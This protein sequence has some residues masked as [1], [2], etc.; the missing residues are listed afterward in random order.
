MTS[1]HSKS[2]KTTK[3]KKPSSRKSTKTKKPSSRKSTK[4]KKPSSRKSTKKRKT[5]VPTT[6]L[7][8]TCLTVKKVDGNLL[9]KNTESWK[10][11]PHHLP[12][13]G[14]TSGSQTVNINLGKKHSNALIYYFAAS[15]KNSVLHGKYPKSYEN[16]TNSGL[17][18]LDKKG[19][20]QVKLDCPMSYTDT[21]FKNTGKQSYMSHIHILVSNKEMTQ[22]LDKLMTQNILCQISKKE[23]QQSVKNRDRLFLNAIALEPKYTLLKYIIPG[24][25]VFRSKWAKTM[26]VTELKEVVLRYIKVLKTHSE[27]KGYIRQKNIKLEDV[28]ITTFCYSKNCSESHDLA[29]ELFRAGFTNVTEYKD[30]MTDWKSN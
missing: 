23:V 1:S 18:K 7:C 6:R 22:W 14:R 15:N 4:N 20:C 11:F 12:V 28:P 26:G 3:S 30:S 10:D 2:T 8:N 9:S 29:M 19:C 16:S 24:S 5:K 27:L 25:L 17:A 13:L 21:N